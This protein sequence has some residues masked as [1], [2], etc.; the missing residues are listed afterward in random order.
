[1]A[2]KHLLLLF[3]ALM[4]GMYAVA[5]P[6]TFS[7]ARQI[8]E[9]RAASLGTTLDSKAMAKA[10]AINGGAQENVANYYV[11][12]NDGG[13]GY[14]IVSGE[15]RM[16]ELVGYSDHGTFDA[17]DMPEAMAAFL[18][19]Y[20]D[21]V[22]AV[23]M[24]DKSALR[25]LAERE[26]MTS[27]AGTR[28][29]AAAVS[30]ML[31]GV[32]RWNQTAPFNQMCPEYNT[33]DDP[34][35]SV[36]GCVATAMAQVMAYWK[37]PKTLQAD[38][39]GYT[40]KS[41]K[42]SIPAIAKGEAYDWDNM[43]PA[44]TSGN[45]TQAQA[46]AVAKLMYHCG[47]AVKMDYG[48]QS[49]AYVSPAHLMDYFGYD[50]DMKS[51][52]RSSFTLA[53]W[54]D[55][56]DKELVAK[57]PI[58]YSGLSSGGGHQFV[59]DGS[60]GN[61]F[62]HINWGWG[63]YQDGYFDITILNPAKGGAGSGNAPDGY[64]R[65]CSMI[66]GIQPENGKADGPLVDMPALTAEGDFES[67]GRTTSITVTQDTRTS[68]ADKFG[69]T[70]KQWWA[71]QSDKAVSA[72]VAFGVN[73]G[74]GGY[75]IVSGRGRISL[76]AMTAS[77]SYSLNHTTL[78]VSYAF[79]EGTY[80]LYALYSTDGGTTWRKCGYYGMHPY[81]L[82]VTE[83]RLTLHDN[84]LTATVTTNEKLYGGTEGTFQLNV[85]NAGD[86]EYMGLISLYAA[87]ATTKP[88]KVAT[89]AYM[90]IPAHSTVTRD[91]A[92]TPPGVGKF[93]VWATDDSDN[94][95][96][97][98]AEFSAG[99]SVAPSLTLVEVKTNATPGAYER[100]NAYLFKDKV[101]LPRVD[102]DYAEFTFSVRNDGSPFTT[103]CALFWYDMLSGG[104]YGVYRTVRFAGDGDITNITLQV[105]PDDID[106]S[107]SIM[108]RMLVRSSTT[109]DDNLQLSTNLPQV[110]Y[111]FVDGSRYYRYDA[112]QPVVYVAGKPNAI[113]GIEANDACSVRGGMGEI[114]VNMPKAGRVAVYG[115]DGRK[116]CDVQVE[117]GVDKRIAVAS[118]MY[119]VGGRKVVVR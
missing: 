109:S 24:G 73:D 54:T 14:T 19:D 95:L 59:C 29:A 119:V 91:V 20:A 9:R 49:G 67:D 96:V 92:I 58:L 101:A 84:V 52:S 65:S 38:I 55:I 81:I 44:Y 32:A 4:A 63:G 13:K 99:Q 22:R 89:S 27:G 86:D 28:A 98:A 102:D 68:S 94:T 26:A 41:Y 83:T 114:I 87:S 15:D 78:N 93:Y 116:V 71:N 5:G 64:N 62:Y 69:I 8:A 77:G 42:L 37:Y 75:T 21:M 17:D 118:G 110:K 25:V 70:L 104:G 105:S 111:Y 18:A 31:D 12:P 46:E 45:Y 10:K 53:Q 43:L 115:I 6:R 34:K 107:R 61:G 108:G 82:K 33:D 100:E 74:N 1:M 57:R 112:V 72:L 30:P 60:D 51:V 35:L 76:S 11:F 106:G 85:T 47:V 39:P 90:T 117:A 50:A 56:I 16:P 2:K 40:T 7:Q 80:S 23:Q 113:A 97:D 103:H 79:K 36:A 3:V 66:I 48:P 88:G